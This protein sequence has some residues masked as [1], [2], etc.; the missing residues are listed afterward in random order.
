MVR[1]KEAHRGTRREIP[2]VQGEIVTVRNRRARVVHSV[3]ERN[4]S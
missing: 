1:E 3:Y 2:S 4:D